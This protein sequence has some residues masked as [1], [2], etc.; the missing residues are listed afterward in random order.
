[1]SLNSHRG[2]EPPPPR[3]S[4]EE[5]FWAKVAPTTPPG[6]CWLWLG[7][8]GTAGYPNFWLNGTNVGAHR[9]SLELNLGRPLLPGMAACHRCDVKRC[10]RPGHLFEGSYSDNERDKAAKGRQAIGE[11]QGLARLTEASVAAIRAS[12][13]PTRALAKQF[14]VGQATVVDVRRRRTWRHVA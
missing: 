9:Y 1:M 6:G 2:G 5:R 8:V 13:A 4:A 12:S 7:S 3:A 11:R 10:V 14:G